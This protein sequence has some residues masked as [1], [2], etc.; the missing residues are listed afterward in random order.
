MTSFQTYATLSI[1][2]PAVA[3]GIF[4]LLLPLV[5]VMFLAFFYY[6]TC[7]RLPGLIGKMIIVEFEEELVEEHKYVYYICGQKVNTFT[8]A[9]ISCVTVLQFL[10]AFIAFWNTFL[11]DSNIGC[12]DDSWDCF[13]LNKDNGSLLFGYD[14]PLNATDCSM[15]E[16]RSNITILCFKF[17]FLYAEGL[18][19]AGGLVFALTLGT[20][21]YIALFVLINRIKSVFWKRFCRFIAGLCGAIIFVFPCVLFTFDK[22]FQTLRTPN[23]ALQFALY[24]VTLFFVVFVLGFSMCLYI[25]RFDAEAELQRR[26]T[27]RAT[28]VY[29]KEMIDA[30]SGLKDHDKLKSSYVEG[31]VL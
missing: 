27:R 17:V 15:F 25:P 8:V 2:I 23:R 29:D 21:L 28:F 10:C 20:N 30:E 7:Q 14:Q 31:S 6:K 9:A 24:M 19:E 4:A 11:T 1:G 22:G 12:A 16:S 3:L 18:S 5:L 13:P 26:A